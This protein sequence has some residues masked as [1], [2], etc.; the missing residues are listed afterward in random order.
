MLKLTYTEVGLHLERLGAPLEMLV[1][2][3]VILALRIGQPL[4]VEPS[5]A[6]FLLAADTPG[7]FQLAVMLQLEHSPGIAITPVDAA[8]VEISLQGSWL[9]AGADAYEGMFI[10]AFADRTEFLICKL[11]GLTEAKASFLF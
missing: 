11:W 3:R 1:A 6:A 4:Q 10:A 9:A 2:Q 7:L 5:R 8:Y